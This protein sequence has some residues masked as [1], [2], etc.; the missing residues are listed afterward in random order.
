M[1]IG[2]GA[3]VCLVNQFRRLRIR[4]EKL[5]DLHEA[6]LAL[7]CILIC[8]KFWPVRIPSYAAVLDAAKRKMRPWGAPSASARADQ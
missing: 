8:W 7:G 5:A 2:R 6:F 3:E 1:A 4:Y